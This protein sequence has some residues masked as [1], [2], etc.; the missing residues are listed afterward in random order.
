VDDPIFSRPDAGTGSSSAARLALK[1]VLFTVLG[2][3][4]LN[5]LSGLVLRHKTVADG[6]GLTDEARHVHD[7]RYK[8]LRPSLAAFV[9]VGDSVAHQLVAQQALTNPNV[10]NL[11]TYHS[12][13]LV[14]QYLLARN[15]LRSHPRVRSIVLIYIPGSFSNDLDYRW[16]YPHF[17]KPLVDREAMS[18]LSPRA[19]AQLR[20]SPWFPIY[21]FPLSK[22]MAWVPFTDYGALEAGPPRHHRGD[23]APISLEYLQAM[24]ALCQAHGV[25]FRVY[26]PPLHPRR[27][28]DLS[29][30]STVIAEAGLEKSF[31]HYVDTVR[32]LDAS[33]FQA[34]RVHIRRERVAALA[35]MYQWW[36]NS[37]A[38]DVH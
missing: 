30:M 16:V 38:D 9:A 24:R 32:V 12:V 22:T 37:A 35:E 17:V 33:D 13:S 20:R 14:G 28:P 10:E 21:P 36:W 18:A 3:F 15:A 4:L 23:L 1:A 8:S 7:A 5:A 31:R 2:G 11:A 27:V 26:S 34:D 19:L 25:S 6:L 29:E